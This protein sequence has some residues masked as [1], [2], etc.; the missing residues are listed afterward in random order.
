MKMFSNQN[1]N[2]FKFKWECIGYQMKIVWDS[3]KN[4]FGFK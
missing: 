1:K 4:V 3:Y 2:Y